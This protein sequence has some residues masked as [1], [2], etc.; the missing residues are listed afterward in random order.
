[1]RW[2]GKRERM[3]RDRGGNREE[4]ERDERGRERRLLSNCVQSLFTV[5]SHSNARKTWFR[6]QDTLPQIEIRICT[7]V[8]HLKA[9]TNRVS[10]SLS[11][12]QRVSV[13]MNR[14]HVLS[15]EK[16]QLFAHTMATLSIR[17]WQG[18]WVQYELEILIHQ[19]GRFPNE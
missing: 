10:T 9:P 4:G 8:R 1:M 17:R 19:K 12:F 18:E 14:R 11:Q 15:V 5:S 6:N 3:R 7:D 16:G 13:S 2:E